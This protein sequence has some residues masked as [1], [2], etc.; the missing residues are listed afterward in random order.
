MCSPE[1]RTNCACKE[2]TDSSKVN[3]V[4]YCIGG[5]LLSMLVPYLAAKGDETI[6]AVTFLAEVFAL[7]LRVCDARP[8]LYRAAIER[9]AVA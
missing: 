6:N 5:T 4:G 1:L 3:P 2:I 7:T 9:T 8:G